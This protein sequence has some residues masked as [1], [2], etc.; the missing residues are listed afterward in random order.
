MM[1]YN[2]QS[3][4]LNVTCIKMEATQCTSEVFIFLSSKGNFCIVT[5]ISISGAS[6]R[7]SVNDEMHSICTCAVSKSRIEKECSCI[8]E[9]KLKNVTQW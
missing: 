9:F 4:K 8:G 5:N 1:W 3:N 6:E 2:A 7:M